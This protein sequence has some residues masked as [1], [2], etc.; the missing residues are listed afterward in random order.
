MK[1]FKN[2]CYRLEYIATTGFAAEYAHPIEA[3]IGNQL[4]A[5]L[6]PIAFG[7][8]FDLWLWFLAF[9]LIRTYVTHCG[10]S[11]PF[12]IPGNVVH[13]DIHHT[14]NVGNYGGT[15]FF[16]LLFGTYNTKWFQKHVDRIMISK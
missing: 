7:F 3:L 10:Y 11:I 13:H 1:F 6:V 4:P 15:P 14:V 9:R 12:L 2:I 8:Q 16:D 5:L